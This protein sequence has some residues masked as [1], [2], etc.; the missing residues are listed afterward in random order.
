[1]SRL[2]YDLHKVN[3]SFSRAR[4]AAGSLPGSL[5]CS[6][7]DNISPYRQSNNWTH[8]GGKSTTPALDPVRHDGRMKLTKMFFQ[9]LKV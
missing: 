2:Q 6:S 9:E 7:F 8:V 5:N 3:M 1:M 4:L